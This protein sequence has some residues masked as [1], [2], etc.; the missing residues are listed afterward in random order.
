MI[1]T[2]QSQFSKANS[3][4]EKSLAINQQ[5]DFKEGMA[6]NYLQ[7]GLLF[8]KENQTTKAAEYFQ[9][10]LAIYQQLGSTRKVQFIKQQLETLKQ[11]ISVAPNHQ[12][13]Q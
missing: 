3:Y 1:Y 9:N 13:E 10:A 4:L 7:F 12:E 11:P 2:E 6:E 8:Q 5:K